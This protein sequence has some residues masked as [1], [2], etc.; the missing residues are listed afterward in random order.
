MVDT[1]EKNTSVQNFE[2]INSRLLKPSIKFCF[3]VLQLYS[4]DIIDT[5]TNN[6]KNF[7]KK[8]EEEKTNSGFLEKK[9]FLS[10][11]FTSVLL[12]NVEVHESQLV[13]LLDDGP[14]EVA[15]PVVLGSDGDDLIL[16]EV[17]GEVQELEE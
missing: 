6:K 14:G 5:I 13:G 10:A 12:R 7:K 17:L 15:G 8:E 11:F 3:K 16:G 4:L 9:Y 1:N 2:S